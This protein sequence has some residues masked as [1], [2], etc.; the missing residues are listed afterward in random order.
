MNLKILNKKEIKNILVLLKKTFGFNDK[1]D[2]AF[3]QNEKGK[4]F[5]ANKEVFDVDFSR[6]KIN[7]IGLYFGKIKNNEI[8]LSIEGAQLIGKN[9]KK[10]IIELNDK[11]K[12]EWMKGIDIDYKGEQ[13]FVLVKY[14]DNFIGCGKIARDKILNFIPKERRLKIVND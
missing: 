10:N 3:L 8:R 4:L 1:L 13:G 2:Y 9:S 12:E 5:I 6:I 14:K 11:Q 7:N